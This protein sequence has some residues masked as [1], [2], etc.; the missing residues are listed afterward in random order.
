MEHRVIGGII[1]KRTQHVVSQA[2]LAKVFVIQF[3]GV[4]ALSA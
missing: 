4:E 1:V 2:Q 3:L